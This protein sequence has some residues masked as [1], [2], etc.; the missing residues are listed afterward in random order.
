L[1]PISHRT[2]NGV[3]VG[4]GL[5]GQF[6]MNTNP[7]PAILLCGIALV[8]SLL[9]GW[10]HLIPLGSR[11]WYPALIGFLGLTMWD[12]PRGWF[13]LAWSAIEIGT[14]LR[15]QSIYRAYQNAW[16]EERARVER[17]QEMG[18][19]PANATADEEDEEPDTVIPVALP[20]IPLWR[21]PV[22]LA[23]GLVP[24]WI[25]GWVIRLAFRILD[26]QVVGILEVLI[27]YLVGKAVSAGAGDRSNRFLQVVAAVLSGASVLYGRYLV[28]GWLAFEQRQMPYSPLDVLAVTV[29]YPAEAL[30]LWML[31]ALGVGVWAGWRYAWVAPRVEY[32]KKV[33]E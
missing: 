27:G 14:G 19:E 22:A 25:G 20:P 26:M 24:A 30:G 1:P 8:A 11:W 10:W 17:L 2:L 18:F 28:L 29:A 31:L 12:E 21:Y 5:L 9:D 16:A 13:F 15:A 7:Q 6:M 4:A 23:V 3:A 32:V 33:E